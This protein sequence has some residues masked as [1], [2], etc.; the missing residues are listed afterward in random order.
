MVSLIIY[1]QLITKVSKTSKKRLVIAK[2]KIY[3]TFFVNCVLKSDIY[4]YHYYT[5]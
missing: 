1:I 3:V 5:K 2:I 4:Y